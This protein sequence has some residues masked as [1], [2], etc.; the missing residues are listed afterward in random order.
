MT[1]SDLKLEPIVATELEISALVKLEEL[2]NIPGNGNRLQLPRIV[3][4]EGEEIELPESVFRLM[5][6]LVPQLAQGKG[7]MSWTF[8]Q[9]LTTWEAASLVDVPRQHLIQLLND[10]EIPST[11]MGWE[12][13]IQFNDLMA[14][15]KKRDELRREALTEI[16]RISEECGLY[17]M[18]Q[19]QANQ[20]TNKLAE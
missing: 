13:K 9:P 19:E 15:K 20:P 14:Y 11:G 3:S 4:P 6:Q 2:L 7:V 5:C 10:G 17:S 18:E 1:A 12:R 16:V 8:H